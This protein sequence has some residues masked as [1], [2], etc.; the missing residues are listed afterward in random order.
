MAKVGEGKEATAESISEGTARKLATYVSR[1][2]FNDSYMAHYIAKNATTG[3][4]GRRT[5][6]PGTPANGLP[7]RS[8]GR[9]F[10]RASLAAASRVGGR[11]PTMTAG[12]GGAGA[13]G[14]VQQG[15]IKT[16]N[17]RAKNRSHTRRKG[18]EARGGGESGEGR[19]GEE[20]RVR[21]R[22]GGRR[23]FVQALSGLAARGGPALAAAAAALL[24]LLL[25]ASLG[26]DLQSWPRRQMPPDQ[27]KTGLNPNERTFLW[28]N[29]QSRTA[30][31]I[32]T[33]LLTTTTTT[34]AS[35]QQS[36]RSTA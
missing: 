35:Q 28:H 33:T 26:G 32:I 10:L 5:A 18:R 34:T 19:E 15:G 14:W 25:L 7:S 8:D 29:R 21:T 20:R 24:L 4:G 27:R 6:R 22:E 31:T 36:E 2:S 12:I 23:Q 11:Q 17:T 1:V 9:P 30:S 16:A 3:V 13:R